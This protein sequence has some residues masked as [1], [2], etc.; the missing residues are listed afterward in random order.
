MEETK[1]TLDS[2]I[3]DGQRDKKVKTQ[4]GGHKHLDNL[5]KDSYFDQNLGRHV[6]GDPNAP[7]S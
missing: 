7:K 2:R 3:Q 4:P 5:I 1:R 6:N